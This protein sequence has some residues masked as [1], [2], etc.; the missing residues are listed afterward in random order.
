MSPAAPRSAA[1]APLHA[2][3]QPH[4]ASSPS[5]AV[6]KRC[7]S[8]WGRWR[9]AR[10]RSSSGSLQEIRGNDRSSRHSAAQL[11]SAAAGAV[12]AR[13]LRHAVRGVA[14]PALSELGYAYDLLLRVVW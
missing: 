14:L 12:W 6:S 3:Q 4:A 1:A 9:A 5:A 2:L 10:R 13:G 7:A 11:L 8:K